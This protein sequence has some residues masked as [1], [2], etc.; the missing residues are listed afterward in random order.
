MPGCAASPQTSVQ[1]LRNAAE[2]PVDYET[3][4]AEGTCIE[5][6]LAHRIGQQ[7]LFRDS[8]GS[9]RENATTESQTEK[10]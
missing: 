7:Y 10:I 1:V 3:A 9:G 8:T 5:G 2:T 4:E 6:I